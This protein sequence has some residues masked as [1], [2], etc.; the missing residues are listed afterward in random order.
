MVTKDILKALRA[1]VTHMKNKPLKGG[2]NP[3]IQEIADKHNELLETV[4][5]LVEQ[6][7]DEVEEGLQHSRIL[8]AISQSMHKTA[9]GAYMVHMDDAEYDSFQQFAANIKKGLSKL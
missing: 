2:Y 3:E 1:F 9:T 7:T 8:L 6:L 4:G 5:Q